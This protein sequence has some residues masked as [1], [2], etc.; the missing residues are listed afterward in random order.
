MSTLVTEP[1][2]DELAHCYSLNGKKLESVT[3]TIRSVWPNRPSFENAPVHVLE[4]ARLR[5]QRVDY[6]C[7]LYA[8]NNGVVDVDDTE[9]VVTRVEIFDAWWNKVKPVY[10]YHQRMVWN[11]EFCGT[12]DLM[13]MIDNRACIIDLKCSHD[14]Q[15][16]WPIQ[17]G[18][19]LDL[20][21]H[22]PRGDQFN[23]EETAVLHI[24][25][26]FKHGYIYKRYDAGEAV[27]WWRATS[28]F[29]LA[30]K[31]ITT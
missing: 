10:L 31:A 16:T 20:Y 23:V 17:V 30:V 26:R 8:E 4:H 14:P 12:L 7:G 11:E 22:T 9:E 29:Y 21:N 3:T 19:Y 25:P 2:L 15:E 28:E 1:V 27:R 13:V 5:G 18:G 24:H 6:W